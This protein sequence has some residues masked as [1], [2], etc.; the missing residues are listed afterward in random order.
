MKKQKYLVSAIAAL[1]M[2]TSAAGFSTFADEVPEINDTVIETVVEDEEAQQTEETTEEESSTVIDKI[3]KSAKKKIRSLTKEA[4]FSGNKCKPAE[5]TLTE[6]EETTSTKPERKA[7]KRA[8]QET[9]ETETSAEE[10]T[11]AKPEK[12]KG[13][14]AGRH[15]K[16]SAEQTVDENTIAEEEIIEEITEE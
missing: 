9:A 14:K 13:N 1:T 11:F 12:S 6:G 7:G 4:K 10:N 5:Q 16:K 2:L 3:I 15:S 8:G